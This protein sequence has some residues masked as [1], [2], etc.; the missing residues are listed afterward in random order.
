[1]HSRLVWGERLETLLE[2]CA[3]RYLSEVQLAA[4]VLLLAALHLAGSQWP[5]PPCCLPSEGA[6]RVEVP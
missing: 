6:E 2:G 5:L 1:M 4:H 3:F